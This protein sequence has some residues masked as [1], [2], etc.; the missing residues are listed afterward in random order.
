VISSNIHGVSEATRHNSAS[1]VKLNDAAKQLKDLANQLQHSVSRFR[2]DEE[3]P[4]ASH[5]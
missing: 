2:V 1:A 4:A 5:E 3:S